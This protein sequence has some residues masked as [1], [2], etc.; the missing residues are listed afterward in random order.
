MTR[1]CN[2]VSSKGLACR[3]QGE[4]AHHVAGYSFPD[5]TLEVWANEDWA[6]P[7]DHTNADLLEVARKLRRPAYRGKPA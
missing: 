1:P 4:H 6:P 5:H 7:E 3:A 2:A